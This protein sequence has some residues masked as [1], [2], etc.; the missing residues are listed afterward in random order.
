MNR[1]L[2]LSSY[3][4]ISLI[5]ISVIIGTI[6]TLD[7]VDNYRDGMLSVTMRANGPTQPSKLLATAKFTPSQF[8]SYQFKPTLAQSLILSGQGLN[9]TGTT[10]VFC[11]LTGTFILF[12]TNTRPH[13]VEGLTET[14]IWQI[15]GAAVI[16]FF[17]LRFLSLNLID[18][19][20]ASLT[21]NA[22][23]Y[24]TLDAGRG[25]INI[26]M[27]SLVVIIT[28]IYELLNY[29]RKLKHENDLTI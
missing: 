10:I 5:L 8:G 1:I 21:N 17:S 27:L 24:R 18:G 14:R 22:F 19:Y 16:L 7:A 11:L 15:V 25:Q 12:M 6:H 23:E 4:G 9:E 28:I 3:A 20:V 2:Q 29:S 26:E 13:L